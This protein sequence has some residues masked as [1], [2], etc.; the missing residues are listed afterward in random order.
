MLNFKLESNGLFCAQNVKNEFF[1][2]KSQKSSWISIISKIRHY[3]SK[4]D[5]LGDILSPYPFLNRFWPTFSKMD[6]F[7]VF[8]IFYAIF[9]YCSEAQNEQI[10]FNQFLSVT[11]YK[12]LERLD[13]MGI[14]STR[15]LKA[16]GPYFHSSTSLK[17]SLKLSDIK[18]WKL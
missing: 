11:W 1:L 2:E 6:F 5:V 18:S 16:E 13:I 8:G 10:W 3:G 7:L 12:I 14:S 17:W 4:T 9:L 15:H